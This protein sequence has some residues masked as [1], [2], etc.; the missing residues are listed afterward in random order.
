MDTLFKAVKECFYLEKK[1]KEKIA[2]ESVSSVTPQW[3]CGRKLFRSP[4]VLDFIPEAGSQADCGG[5]VRA[6]C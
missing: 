5:R 1:R 2:S 4:I 6:L 3:V